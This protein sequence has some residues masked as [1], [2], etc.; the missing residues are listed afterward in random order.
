MLFRSRAYWPE[1]TLVSATSADAKFHGELFIGMQPVAGEM[2][3][4]GE[5]VD[6]LPL[7]ILGRDGH[8]RVGPGRVATIDP[9]PVRAAMDAEGA[10]VHSEV[11]LRICHAPT[12]VFSPGETR[13]LRM[14]YHQ[15]DGLTDAAFSDAIV[16]E[17]STGA[18]WS[19]RIQVE[20]SL[21]VALTE[22]AMGH[23]ECTWAQGLVSFFEGWA[24]ATAAISRGVVCVFTFGFVCP[25]SGGSAASPPELAAY[26]GWMEPGELGEFELEL[27][28]PTEP[29]TY[30]I[31]VTVHGSNYDATVTADVLVR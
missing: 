18:M 14:A 5:P 31:E 15:P 26:P 9:M 10:L 19:A 30:A 8:L 13:I 11:E 21:P 20:G 7:S 24:E 6:V 2:L 23:P 22:P 4:G 16:A 3:A 27:T 29:G 12:L 17:L 25:D 28:A 1:G